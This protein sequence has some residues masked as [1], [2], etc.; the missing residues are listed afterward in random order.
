MTRYRPIPPEAM[1]PEQLEVREEVIGGPR[2]RM[3]PPVE[4]WIRSPELASHAAKLGGY[5]RFKSSL[6][7]R[8]HEIAVL[9]T[10][11]HWTSQFE[12]WAHARLAKEAG[13]PDAVIDAIRERRDPKI[14]DAKQ[15]VVYRVAKMLLD[16]R[17]QLP[18]ALFAEAQQTLGEQGLV[19][20][21][22]TVGYYCFVSLTLNAFEVPVPGGEQPLS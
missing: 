15:A 13:I 6:P 3:V 8:L 22:A 12:W 10:G 20:V 2:G 21:V 7:P 16:Q 5:I 9:V 17:G 1:T 18:D 14:D 4:V 11:R 19:D